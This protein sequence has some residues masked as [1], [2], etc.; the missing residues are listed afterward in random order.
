MNPKAAIVIHDGYTDCEFLVAYHYLLAHDFDVVVYS[1]HSG[2]VK[3]VNGW[4]HKTSQGMSDPFTDTMKN[5]DVLVLIGGVK[6]MEYLRQ[7]RPLI[8]W[9]REH[10]EKGGMIAS[11][12]HGA[13]LLIEADIIEGRLVTGYYSIRRDI[14]NADGIYAEGA[15]VAI[16]ANDQLV[17]S[18]HYDYSGK[19][20]KAAVD[21]WTKRSQ[22]SKS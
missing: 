11:I 7:Y 18:P 9:I 15:T 3:G 2:P 6:A 10:D 12:C 8:E 14:T 17:T 22:E 5:V 19:W 4:I 20:I 21:T 16:D 13:Q 1:L